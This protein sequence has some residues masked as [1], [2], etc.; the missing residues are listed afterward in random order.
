MLSTFRDV[1][2]VPCVKLMLRKCLNLGFLLIDCLVYRQ[3]VICLIR[4]TRYEHYAGEVEDAGA[5]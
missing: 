1:F 3:N 4:F 5:L 2:V